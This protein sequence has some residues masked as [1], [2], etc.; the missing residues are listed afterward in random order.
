MYIDD[1]LPSGALE[2]FL[3]RQENADIATLKNLVASEPD[4]RRVLDRLNGGK[5][6]LCPSLYM[7][8][9]VS[10]KNP[11]TWAYYFTKQREGLGGNRLKA[12]HGAEIPYV[13]NTH[14]R[15]LPVDEQDKVL[16]QKMMTFW[17]NFAKTGNPNGPDLPRWP[18]VSERKVMGLGLHV[19]ARS[20]PES[21]MCQVFD[22]AMLMN[23]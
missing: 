12:Y 1:P 23:K 6:N 9:R 5:E 16:T 15:W 8:R 7:A 20:I 11:N 22:R 10:Q 2:S 21:A 14:D 3:A 17:V 13:F 4:M 19:G 18:P